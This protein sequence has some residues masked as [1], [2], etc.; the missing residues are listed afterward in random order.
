MSEL[1]WADKRGDLLAVDREIAAGDSMA[2]GLV[3]E[4]CFSSDIPLAVAAGASKSAA[5]LQ[6]E[7]CIR[8]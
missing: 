6:T 7:I 3:K 1:H 2:D 8:L 5:R 4:D